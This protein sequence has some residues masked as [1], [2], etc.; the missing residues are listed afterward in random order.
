MLTLVQR[1]HKQTKKR[2]KKSNHTVEVTLCLSHKSFCLTIGKPSCN[3]FNSPE[4][5]SMPLSSTDQYLFRGVLT[6]YY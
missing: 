6:V 5:K 3:S 1:S 4:L 2:K